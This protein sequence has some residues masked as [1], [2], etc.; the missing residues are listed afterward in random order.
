VPVANAAQVLEKAAAASETRR[1]VAPRDDQWI[2][3][4]E[5]FTRSPGGEPE[6]LRSWHRADGLGRAWID[7]AGKLRVMVDEAPKKRLGRPVPAPLSGYKTLAALPT[8]PGALLR[9]AYAQAK[10]ITNG[11]DSTD[12]GEVYLL[13]NHMLRE[14]VLPPGLEAGIFRA[15]KQIPGLT[16]D[17][18][19]IFGRPTLA[20]GLTTA[21]WLHEELLLDPDT[22]AYRGARSTV[23]KDATI[24]PAKAGNS[25]GRVTKGSQVITERVVTAIVDEPGRRP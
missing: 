7:E 12:D 13:F 23:I 4:E 25:T 14:I 20:L 22:H 5:R 15:M 24:D 21:D 6:I 3:I 8:D 9:W 10:H 17:T 2:Y 18:V 1:I 19:K 16:V 11:P